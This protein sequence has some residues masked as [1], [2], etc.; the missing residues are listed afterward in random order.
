M[1]NVLDY[2]RWRG[3][4]SFKES[5]FNEID[6]M[7]LARLSYI[8]F[9]R[10]VSEDFYEGILLKD[11][12][13]KFLKQESYKEKFLW[14]ADQDFLLLLKDSIRFRNLELCSYVNQ[15][16]VEIQKQFCAITI[17]MMEGEYYISYRGTD[18]TLIGWKEDFNMAFLTPIPSQQS[19]KEYFIAATEYLSGTFILGGHS[20]G[21]N[22]A[23]YASAS[24]N[25]GYQ[26]VI[27]SVYNFDG[28][29][30]EQNILSTAGYKNISE[31][32]YTYIPE[33]SVVGMLLDHEEEYVIVKSSQKGIMQHDIYSW[34]L[35]GKH[36]VEGKKLTK[37]SR[38]LDASLKEW[39]SDMD[40]VQRQQFVDAIFTV[41]KDSQ[42][43]TTEEFM[44]Q[45]HKS[46]GKMMTSLKHMDEKDKRNV[47]RT[48]NSLLRIITKNVF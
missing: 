28:P 21:G 5:G 33:S 3:D 30:F 19:A 6:A 18:S 22:L 23:V 39:V 26:S 25:A 24:C 10:I 20:K 42:A 48:I 17:K 32:L 40:Y 4:L 43:E 29:G 34:E 8:P 35:L 13:D 41:F 14:P 36:F 1:S 37:E 46:I 11:A 31:R 16:D 7:V 2:L 27:R 38:M 12:A 47:F 44:S 15:I 9:D 45:W